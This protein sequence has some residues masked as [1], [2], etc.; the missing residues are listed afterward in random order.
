M[1]KLSK[2]VINAIRQFNSETKNLE[3]GDRNE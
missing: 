2:E 1:L 3:K